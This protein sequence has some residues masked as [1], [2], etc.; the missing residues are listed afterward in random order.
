MSPG[1]GS[2]GARVRWSGD[3]EPSKGEVGERACNMKHDGELW[4][5]SYRVAVRTRD[6][7]S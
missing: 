1:D 2:L 4:G 3:R 6:H 5:A 7:L